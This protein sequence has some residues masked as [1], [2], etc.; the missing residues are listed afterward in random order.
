MWEGSYGKEPFDLRLTVLRLIRQL[1]IIAGVTLAGTILFGGAYCIRHKLA[2]EELY[3]AES[4]YHVE[5]PVEEE[6]DVGVVYIN[7]VTWNT[8][9]DSDEFLNAV[10]ERTETG[11]TNQELA[12]TL[13]AVLA[14]DLRVPS[15]QVTTNDPEISMRIAQAVEEVMTEVF[16]DKIREILSVSVIGHAAEAAPVVSDVRAGRAF[17]LSA[18]LSCF[19]VVVFL[20]LKELGEDAVWLPSTIG[21]RYG[22]KVAGTLESAELQ[23]NLHWFFREKQSVAVSTVQEQINSLQLVEELRLRCS[24]EKDISWIA[25]PSLLLAPESCRRIRETDGLLLAVRAGKN[26]GKQLEAAIEFM[27]QQDCK[28]TAVILCEADEWLLRN[29]YRWK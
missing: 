8:Y 7:A 17:A 19:F 16:P 10:Q 15:T 20:L 26:A 2:E 29:Y 1:H 23:E 24:E 27:I 11:M 12:E 3:C 22:L 18:V 14:S 25:L 13:N 6:K 9:L 21:K 4:V 5:Y 28:I